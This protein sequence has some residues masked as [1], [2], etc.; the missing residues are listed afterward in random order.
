[1]EVLVEKEIIGYGP[2]TS[3][4][5]TLTNIP[6]KP[7][8]IKLFIDASPAITSLVTAID[9]GAGNIIGA[10]VIGTIEYS[11]GNIILTITAGVG[12][13]SDTKY[14]FVSYTYYAIGVTELNKVM[15]SNQDF[16]TNVEELKEFIRKNYPDEYN[17]YVN[18]SLGMALID[19][20]AYTGQNLSWYMNRKVTDLYF[21]TARTPNSI[22]KIARN[23]GYKPA[24]ARSAQ[25]N[26][27]ITLKNGPYT[28]PIK[29]ERPFAFK[30]P[31]G[32]QF[33]YRNPVAVTFLVGETYKSFD[34]NEGQS[35]VDNFVANGETNQIFYL[36]R[37]TSDKYIEEGSIVV[38]ING[39]EWVEYPIIPF[40]KT[41]AFET[42]ILSTPPFIKFGDGIQGQVPA[43]GL[44][45]E[46]SYVICN[47]FSGRIAKDSITAPLNPLNVSFTEIALVIS[48]PSASIGGENPE[49]L[50]SI[51]INAPLFQKTQD[52]AI[53]K[54][55][56][57]Y[58]A[59]AY[60]N[61]A[62]ADAQVIRSISDDVNIQDFLANMNTY[63][64]NLKNADRYLQPRP[65]IQNIVLSENVFDQNTIN[66]TI[67]VNVY[68]QA[69]D[70]D[71]TT[72]L[73]ALATTLSGDS[74]IDTAIVREELS[75][76]VVVLTG[77]ANQSFTVSGVS[78][79]GGAMPNVV[80]TELTSAP[81]QTQ[82]ITFDKDL[83]YG[84]VF[85]FT[86]DTTPLAIPFQS[87]FETT[88]SNIASAISSFAKSPIGKWKETATAP[89]QVI[90]ITFD[91]D[92]FNGCLIQ[93]KVQDLSE[94]T[95]VETLVEVSFRTNNLVTYG[96]L[97]A[98]FEKLSFINSVTIN[99]INRTLELTVETAR[100]NQLSN[101]V[102]GFGDSIKTDYNFAL[103]NTPIKPNSVRIQV[104][105]SSITDDGLGNLSG[106]ASGSI[107]YSTGII[108]LTFLSAPASGIIFYA[109][110]THF[111]SLVTMEVTSIVVLLATVSYD[112]TARTIDVITDSSGSLNISDA[113]VVVKN[114][115]IIST[116]LIQNMIE[117]DLGSVAGIAENIENQVINLSDYLVDSYADGCKSN[118]VQVSVL[119]LDAAK[120]YAEPTE[121]L[122]SSLQ[123]YLIE[124]KDVVHHVETISG[125]DKVINV[126]LDIEV[127][128]VVNSI[129]EEIVKK[130][131]RSLI[132]ADSLPYGLLV[133]REFNKSLY[134]SEVFDAIQDYVDD[135]ERDYL[136]IVIKGPKQH[137]TG[138]V[139]DELIGL[140]LPAVIELPIIKTL[141]SIP[142][143]EG[144]IDIN[145]DGV[146]AGYDDGE[147]QILAA[148]G[149]PTYIAQG[150]VDYQTGILNIIITP[151]PPE[152]MEVTATYYQ[153]KIDA[154][155]NYICPKGYVLQYGT[156]IV[157]PLSRI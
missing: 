92:F 47:G 146:L 91:K 110:Y 54:T 103:F 93:I 124:R 128:V 137:L 12:L 23:L 122:L 58:L 81:N 125:Y 108:V 41:E 62:K 109:N 84:N 69:F 48:Q 50:R 104:G 96:D 3:I 147:G 100:P 71:N 87:D 105:S 30:A 49:D 39:V 130:I 20:I 88:L 148:S 153:S 76:N 139:V 107:D 42:N 94:A 115:P 59:N 53:T 129:Q 25:V 79:V 73:T 66:V 44:G 7:R 127:L 97:K 140:G 52:R 89:N 119:S 90:L 133:Q 6:I 143:V 86:Y 142:V 68:S 77:V 106:A 113:I 29:I 131:E 63:I 64:M 15:Y 144:Q 24:G 141:N 28:F 13:S 74:K 80:V 16:V 135:S 37:V 134:V 155:G 67:G 99:A 14:A 114:P 145:V 36:R 72:T 78:V 156:V 157:R 1:V 95:P 149:M 151:A 123:S 2:T 70:T 65:Q 40:E 26:L 138:L 121:T 10:G 17:D 38:K 8:S 132:Q 154:R 45:I 22:S 102:V 33:E 56:Y 31:N 112:V 60:P 9:D 120:K 83:F 98:A 101:E 118:T 34:V 21:P 61:V 11:T 126:D 55:D 43:N 116:N 75:G 4:E 82:R 27:G 57:D 18:S 150:V 19:I 117:E 32:L 152:E 35:V 111:S 51:T 85:E 46:V 5:T 136:N